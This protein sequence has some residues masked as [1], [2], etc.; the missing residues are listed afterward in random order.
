MNIYDAKQEIKNTLK[1]YLKKNEFGEYA[2]SRVKQR[3]VLLIGAPGLGK[4]AIMSQIAE[5]TGVALVSYS[6]T[7]H[8]RQ[9]A[10]GLPFINDRIYGDTCYKITEYTMSE[11]IA[12]VYETMEQTG[13]KEGIL[14]IDEINC[15]SET[16][17]P[18]MLQFLQLKQFGQH[19]VPEGWVVVAAGNPP[20]YNKSVK[21]FD[22]V[23]LDR[24]KMIHVEANYK[25]WKKYAYEYRVH[26]A[27][28]S[29]LDINENN[30]YKVE[31]TVDGKEIVTARGWDDLS[32]VINLYEESDIPVTKSLILQYIQHK[33][34]ATHFANYYDLYNKY[35]KDYHI[36]D[37]LA[38][39][40]NQKDR[41]K[42]VNAPFDERLSFLSILLE[43]IASLMY[44]A[45]RSEH[46]TQ[47]LFTYLKELKKI[48]T[49][50]AFRYEKARDYLQQAEDLLQENIEGKKIDKK[51]I[52]NYKLA[53]FLLRSFIESA[54]VK[55]GDDAEKAFE[56]I[57]SAFAARVEEDEQ[58]AKD[59]NH[60]LDNAF[61][62]ISAIFGLGQEMII[63]VTELTYNYHCVR[64]LAEHPNQY[65]TQYNKELLFDQ[66]EA[67]LLTDM[68][69]LDEMMA[70]L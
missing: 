6:I 60:S 57:K 18:T 24:I 33:D 58:T 10:I 55:A 65:Y 30:F 53:L 49:S 35:K 22:T 9:S 19:K 45:T 48:Y 2:I 4:T 46:T 61:N 62:F 52:D 17:A 67:A 25:V 51:E 12:S 28:I 7:H 44:G 11:I 47:I 31:N 43:K 56:E 14:F 16:L 66:K 5:E 63:F 59:I 23:T 3:P 1:I 64:F 50:D 39:T 21:E 42:I 37:I 54:N 13:K 68:K 29:Y 26:N 34:V 15:A 8:T 32:Q 27:I 40:I 36:D 38:G 69:K 20:E 70:E 41:D